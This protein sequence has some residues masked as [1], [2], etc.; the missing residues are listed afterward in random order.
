MVQ[1]AVFFFNLWQ[2]GLT[3]RHWPVQL[4]EAAFSVFLGG[5]APL[6]QN[7]NL[8]LPNVKA[9]EFF[10]HFRTCFVT[11]NLKVITKGSVCSCKHFPSTHRVFELQDLKKGKR[12]HYW[13]F[14]F[15]VCGCAK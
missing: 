13:V 11:Y 9:K 8:L 7:E 15:P 10:S 5:L 12:K 3:A 1:P 2:S 6:K 4:Q 14:Q